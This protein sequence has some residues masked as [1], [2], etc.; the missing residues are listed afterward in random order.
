MFVIFSPLS[1]SDYTID[2]DI[3]NSGDVPLY[4]F[5][6][7]L[8]SIIASLGYKSTTAQL[9]TV[10][11]YAA[12]AILTITVGCEFKSDCLL[13]KLSPTNAR[14]HR[15]SNTSKRPLQY[16]HLF[17]WYGRFRDAPRR[18]SSPPPLKVS[19]QP[20]EDTKLTAHVLE[21]RQD[22][23]TPAPSLVPLGS[24]PASQT[25]SR[26]PPTT[27]KASTSA[28]SRWGSSSAGAI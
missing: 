9:L 20:T 5:S 14:R 18:V 28:A 15:R 23:A 7:F 1:L 2:T 27:R 22:S 12:A 16:L 11:P 10:P 17:P 13:I 3:S 26:G 25:P 6:L 4:A 24:I 8:P 19:R 21:H